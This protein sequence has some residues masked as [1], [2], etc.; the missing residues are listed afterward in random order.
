MI[1]SVAPLDEGGILRALREDGV[2]RDAVEEVLVP[3]AAREREPRRADGH[4]RE[5]EARMRGDEEARRLDGRQ[6]IEDRAVERVDRGHARGDQAVY[7]ATGDPAD[8][9]A[10][11]AAAA[12]RRR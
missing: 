7:L 12:G 5:P 2:E 11:A 4:G 9:A 6:L 8:G 1:G 10:A 3:V